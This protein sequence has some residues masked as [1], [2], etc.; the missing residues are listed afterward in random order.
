M[1]SRG[2]ISAEF[3]SNPIFAGWRNSGV[4]SGW[5]GG[6]EA[7]DDGSIFVRDGTWVSPAVAA[8]PLHWYRLA[9][10]SRTRGEAGDVANASCKVVFSAVQA[11]P[12]NSSLEFAVGRSDKWRKSDFRF[13][14]HPTVDGAGNLNPTTMRVEFEERGGAYVDIDEVVIEATSASEAGKWADEFYEKLPAKLHYAVKPTRWRRLGGTIEKLQSHQKVR[15]VFMGD[16]IGELAKAP[17]DVYLQRLYPGCTVEV[18]S[19]SQDGGQ[20]MQPGEDLGE[21]V[22][23]L[24]PD[25]VI[26]GGWSQG[27]DMAGL[28]AVVDQVRASNAVTKRKTEILLLTRA[29]DAKML[30]GTDFRLTSDMREI[31][32]EP[33]QNAFVPDDERGRLMRFAAKNGIEF[34]DMMGIASEFVFRQAALAA[35]GPPTGSDG[36]PLSYWVRDWLHP[37][38]SSKQIMGKILEAYF[39]PTAAGSGQAEATRQG[40]PSAPVRMFDPE[41]NPRDRTTYAEAK[42]EFGASAVERPALA[43]RFMGGSALKEARGSGTGAAFRVAGQSVREAGYN[44]D[45]ALDVRSG[46][47]AVYWSFRSSADEG[48]ENGK[49]TMHLC[50]SDPTSS[51]RDDR[52][53]VSLTVRPGGPSSLGVAGGGRVDSD[54]ERLVEAPVENFIDR[55]NVAKFRMLLRWV[56]GDRVVVEAASWNARASRW[57]AFIPFDRP[58]APAFVLELSSARNLR[59]TTTFKSIY[60]EA[61]SAVP[62]LESVLVVMRPSMIR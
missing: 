27:S 24:K 15:L 46:D 60:F 42:R 47:I 22:V 19:T 11:E 40:A 54:V 29:W 30:G 38:E 32:Q 56:G 26:I 52:A 41:H 36:V 55:A 4:A 57:E 58:G 5:R 51:G 10:R 3:E 39:A 33:E 50:F 13:R 1:R 23:K 34:L 48:E 28:Q 44:F 14:A 16:G 49:L 35:V 18:L 31:D 43:L 2:L 62:V 53:Q 12:S 7:V 37:V 61:Q 9:F 25:L 21:R 6:G 45:E 8:E 20:T 59:G 17:L